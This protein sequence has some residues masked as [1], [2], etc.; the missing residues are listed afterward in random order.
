MDVPIS[1]GNAY[2]ISILTD[3]ESAAAIFNG[4]ADG[5]EVTMPFQNVF[6]G[7]MFGSTIDKFGIHW[8][9]SSDAENA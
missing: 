9:I 7:G 8:M 6:W 4:F 5:G 3:E 1:Q 2:S